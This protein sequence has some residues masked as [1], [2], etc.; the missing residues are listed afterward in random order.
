M[1]LGLLASLIACLALAGCVFN[2]FEAIEPHYVN[3][4]RL[5]LDA[6]RPVAMN[7]VLADT[8]IDLDT[9]EERIGQLRKWET[10]VVDG[11]LDNTKIAKPDYLRAERDAF[12]KI[13]PWYLAYITDD[14][15]LTDAE[16]QT[17]ADTVLSWDFRLKRA[18]S[19]AGLRGPPDE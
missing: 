1:R 11:E 8:T 3:A 5:T 2:P 13:T 9:R 16:K 19:A 6:I 14:P 12:D 15:G 18:E 4:E 17:K 7:Y 10:H